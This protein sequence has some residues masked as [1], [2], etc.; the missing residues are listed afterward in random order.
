MASAAMVTALAFVLAP[1]A[2]HA[3]KRPAAAAGSGVLAG[4]ASAAPH[5]VPQPPDAA[6]PPAQTGPVPAAADVA[7]QPP[8]AP[9]RLPP[10]IAAALDA[11]GLPPSALAVVV[12][13][14][15]DAAAP[16]GASSASPVSLAI[17]P[18]RVNPTPPEAA[19]GQE[20]I[21][22]RG[23]SAQRPA[24]ADERA[25]APPALRLSLAAHEPRAVAS[26]MKL[27]TTL[28]ALDRLGPDWRWH[29]PVW[30][31]GPVRGGVLHGSLHIAAAGD[32]T[33]SA[34]R[35]WLLVQAVRAQG[36]REI[37]GDIVIDDTAFAELPGGDPAAFDGEPLRPYNVLPRGLVLAQQAVLLQLRPDALAGLARVSTLPELAGVDWP[38]SVPLEPAAACGDW[39]TALQL[40]LANP[41]RPQLRGRYPL[42]C[43]A[44]DWPLAWPE[45][46]P[47]EHARRAIEAAWRQAGG[48]LGGQVRAGPAPAGLA[49]TLGFGSPPLAEVVRSI[50][51]YSNN[52]M[53]RLL[54]LT[55]GSDAA[56]PPAPLP[57]D[58]A[59][60]RSLDAAARSA[61]GFASSP[62]GAVAPAVLAAADDGPVWRPPLRPATLERARRLVA[63]WAVQRAGCRPGELVLDNGSGLSREERSSAACL[64]AV[65]QAAWASPLMPELL[66]SLPV[67]GVDGTAR[68]LG[69]AEAAGRAHLKTG[70][71][72]DVMA[73]AG[74][75]LGRSGARHAVVVLINDPRAAAARP[76]LDAVLRW[77]W[78][79]LA[80]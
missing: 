72:R 58:A 12:L 24:T 49:P 6:S 27:F 35:L 66:A 77:A 15:N 1:Q 16:G 73:A 62:S 5:A 64:A 70:S 60:L 47:G 41:N 9:G 53:A 42:A 40:D 52:P 20:A 21:E 61:Q 69:G 28:A 39:R 44:R 8:G 30:L 37:R 68:R 26:L 33:L 19:A 74:V 23:V 29:T 54:F 7:P 55:L 50:N 25:G 2:A 34:E 3:G 75:V 4:A 18:D 31:A 59:A 10:G 46:Q 67:A 80:P 14:L 11:T 13:R 79:D 17:P 51:K 43:G 36:V 48:G 71:L 65:L 22:A 32:P 56:E 63:D 38:A 78:D 76:V 57:P 45:P